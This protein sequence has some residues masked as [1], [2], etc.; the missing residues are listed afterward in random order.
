MSLIIC[1]QYLVI[2]CTPFFFCTFAS[3]FEMINGTVIILSLDIYI[4]I[5][6]VGHLNKGQVGD[7]IKSTDL[8]VIER[9]FFIS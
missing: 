1:L 2:N 4:Y 9:F 3:V 8:S 5:I 6:T 7:S